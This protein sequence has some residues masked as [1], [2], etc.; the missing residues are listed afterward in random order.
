MDPAVETPV[1]SIAPKC[2]SVEKYSDVGI[3][4]PS[5]TRSSVRFVRFAAKRTRFITFGVKRC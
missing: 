1:M 3:V 5:G 4:I 2:G